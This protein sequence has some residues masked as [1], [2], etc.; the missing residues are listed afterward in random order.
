MINHQCSS[1][2]NK[3]F[4]PSILISLGTPVCQPLAN[5]LTDRTSVQEAQ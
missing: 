5:S 4:T 2:A 1:L 3:T